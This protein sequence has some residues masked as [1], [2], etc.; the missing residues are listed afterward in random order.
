M[1][2]LFFSFFGR[3]SV[4]GFFL[5]LVRKLGNRRLFQ[6][7]LQLLLLHVHLNSSTSSSLFRAA[8]FVFPFVRSLVRSFV[9]LLARESPNRNRRQ[10]QRR[11]LG[12]VGA[13]KS[14]SKPD[15]IMDNALEARERFCGRDAQVQL[16]CSTS[17]AGRLDLSLSNSFVRGVFFSLVVRVSWR[18][19]INRRSTGSNRTCD[20][21]RTVRNRATIAIR[22]PKNTPGVKA[23]NAAVPG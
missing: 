23:N 18:N 15:S 20:R 5:Y 14:G 12:V 2:S 8:S 6:L 21:K 19:S 11:R 4:F 1:Y 22:R 10:R 3:L 9:H 16:L 7:M 13:G 17:V